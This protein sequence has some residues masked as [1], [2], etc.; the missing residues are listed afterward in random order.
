LQLRLNK[1]FSI[2]K[3]S[4]NCLVI[5]HLCGFATIPLPLLPFF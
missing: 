5:S 1:L 4:A 3:V 2:N